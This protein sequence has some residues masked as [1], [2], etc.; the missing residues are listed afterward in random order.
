MSCSVC[1]K[2]KSQSPE[3][4]LT[5]ADTKIS[6]A[7]SHSQALIIIE[8]PESFQELDI[9]ERKSC[10]PKTVFCDRVANFRGDFLRDALTLSWTSWSQMKAYNLR[11]PTL[12]L[13]VPIAASKP[14]L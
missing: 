10:S 13:L 4:N 2:P 7:T 3:P 11:I 5:G 8:K 1:V 14:E 12:S 6:L 9:I